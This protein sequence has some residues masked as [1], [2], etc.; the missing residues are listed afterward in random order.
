MSVVKERMDD[1]VLLW[2]Q[3]QIMKKKR[4]KRRERDE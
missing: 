2:L 1:F 4:V 3:E